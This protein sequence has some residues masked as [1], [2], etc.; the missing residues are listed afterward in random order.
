MKEKYN[1][2]SIAVGLIISILGII[3]ILLD[4]FTLKTSQNL[5]ISIGCSLIA[6]GLVILLTALLVERVKYNPLDEWGIEKIYSTRAEK[7]AD[8]DPKL[9]KAKYCVDVVAFG[10][11]S[12]RTKHN[13]KVDNCLKK[14]VNFR[15]LTMA[16]DSEF[17]H[18][19]EKEE[20]ESNGQ[21]KNTI[22]QL[23]KWADD[24]NNNN[25]KGKIIVKG[26]KC[27]TLDFYWR[28]DSEVYIGP[29]WYGIDSQQTITYKFTDG[30]KGFI[31][32][33]DYFEQLWTDPELS[34]P[35]TQITEISPKKQH[36]F[37][38]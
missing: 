31:Q 22:N 8:S 17:I 36:L 14:G 10:L 4:L 34:E 25:Y 28:V 20:K 11:K 3:G 5:W 19:R 2:K 16:P 7:N 1:W 35:L 23:V 38:K 21:I 27:M 29:Y 12:F 9:S 24:K 37:K 32:Y 26:Y 13:D 33:T 15:I 30:G 6:S 18:Q